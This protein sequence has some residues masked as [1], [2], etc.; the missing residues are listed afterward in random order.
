MISDLF[1]LIG[2]V[3]DDT[4]RGL[5]RKSIFLLKDFDL[6]LEPNGAN[7]TTL[8][9]AIMHARPPRSFSACDP[10]CMAISHCFYVRLLRTASTCGHCALLLRA[11]TAHCFYVRPLHT[12]FTCDHLALLLHAATAHCFYMRPHALSPYAATMWGTSTTYVRM[13]YVNI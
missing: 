7:A 9:E 2:R 6:Q 12:A 13:S 5:S 10:S 8:C 1:L 4:Q 11:A 3:D